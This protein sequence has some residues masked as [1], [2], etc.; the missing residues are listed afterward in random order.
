VGDSERDFLADQE[1]SQELPGAKRVRLYWSAWTFL[2]LEN[3]LP[4]LPSKPTPIWA[5]SDQR[6]GER[7]HSQLELWTGAHTVPC[8]ACPFQ[9]APWVE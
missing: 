3:S 8:E 6:Y 7:Y 1:V 5:R 4:R 2:S 9:E